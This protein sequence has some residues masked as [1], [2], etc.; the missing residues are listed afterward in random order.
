LAD[1]GKWRKMIINGDIS[2]TV[3]QKAISMAS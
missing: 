3:A 1:C 2:Q